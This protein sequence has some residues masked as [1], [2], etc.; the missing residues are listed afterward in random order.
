MWNIVLRSFD[1]IKAMFILNLAIVPSQYFKPM[2]DF[3]T[4]ENSF[5]TF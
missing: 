5:L 4:P 3:Y 2:F 1:R